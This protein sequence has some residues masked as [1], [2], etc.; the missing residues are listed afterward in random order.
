MRN[1]F[2]VL[3]VARDS[4]AA[5]IRRFERRVTIAA[6]LALMFGAIVQQLMTVP[7]EVWQSVLYVLLAYSAAFLEH[8]LVFELALGGVLVILLYRDC[9]LVQALRNYHM[10]NPDAAQKETNQW[11]AARQKKVALL[12]FMWALPLQVAVALVHGFGWYFLVTLLTMLAM[13]WWCREYD[14]LGAEVVLTGGE[15]ACVR[16]AR[17]AGYA[18]GRFNDCDAPNANIEAYPEGPVRDAFLAGTGE[19]HRMRFQLRRRGIDVDYKGD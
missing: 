19:G 2:E 15:A 12:V 7:A 17:D 16:R 3:A 14:S 18:Y 9:L 13:A 8:G 10:K 6:V 1:N 4:S 5:A 11:L